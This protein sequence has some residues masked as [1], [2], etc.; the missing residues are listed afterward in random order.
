M[1]D[2]I[3]TDD[4]VNWPWSAYINLPL[5]PLSLI[6]SRFQKSSS[7]LVIP[8]LISWFPSSP[9]GEPA[10]RL[11]EYWSKPDNALQLARFSLFSSPGST[12]RT[13]FWPPPPVLFALVGVPFVKALYRKTYA[14]AYWK[15]LKAPQPVTNDTRRNVL[16]FNEGPLVIRILANVDGADGGGNPAQAQ[17]LP[18]GPAGAGAAP[19]ADDAE[20]D[21]EAAAIQAAEQL[22]DINATSLGRKVGGALLI[23]AISSMMGSILLR[24][25]TRSY[26]LRM[27]LGI[28]PGQASRAMRAERNWVTSLLVGNY[29]GPGSDKSLNEQAFSSTSPD[30]NLHYPVPP[31][32]WSRLLL[33][34]SSPFGDNTKIWNSM[35]K[36]QQLKV[37]LQLVM[38]AVVHGSRMWMETD[39]VW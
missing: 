7:S 19:A 37:G 18:N 1:F 29:S 30:T 25:S 38:N 14:W 13:K 17:G 24:L 34:N 21:P 6:I 35:S 15:V 22:I 10:R 20:A 33:P 9:V 4:P 32:S 5:L 2:L 12:H 26:L 16:R 39:P 31:L 11:Y 27:F 8:L 23:P 28:R 36:F 3:L